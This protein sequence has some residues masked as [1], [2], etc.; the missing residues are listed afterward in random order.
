MKRLK[1]VQG[2]LFLFCILPLLGQETTADQETPEI[3]LNNG[4]IEQRIDYLISSSNNYQ[5][6]KVVKKTALNS[7]KN[8]ILDT[9]KGLE[10]SL[11]KSN[12]T[13]KEKSKEIITLQTDLKKT[14]ED[15]KK[16]TDEKDSFSFF[17]LLIGK[18]L[19]SII[20]WG[21]IIALLVGL[22]MVFGM[23][24]RANVITLKTKKEFNN[25]EEEFDNY[26][27]SSLEREQKIKRELQDYKNKEKY[28]KQKKSKTK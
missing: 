12:K 26:R 19:Y 15:L 1:K 14:N 13:I 9:I 23:F 4:T 3:N 6:Y 11:D 16:V 25:I 7:I 5:N 21:I 18:S 28:E 20:L 10:S 2:L 24:K 8:T 27:K 17:G 22:F